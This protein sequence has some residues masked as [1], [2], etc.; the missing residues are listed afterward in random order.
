G[1]SANRST[2][3]NRRE[4]SPGGTTPWTFPV[5]WSTSTQLPALALPLGNRYPLAVRAPSLYVHSLRISTWVNGELQRS[6]S[7]TMPPCSAL[8]ADGRDKANGRRVTKCTACTGN[9]RHFRAHCSSFSPHG[10]PERPD[11]LLVVQCH[12]ALLNRAIGTHSDLPPGT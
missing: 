8:P 12:V 4:N 11:D 5:A 1:T 10:G 9:D 7:S 6:G 3:R 2:G